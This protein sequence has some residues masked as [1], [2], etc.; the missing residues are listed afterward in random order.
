MTTV[1]GLGLGAGVAFN[2]VLLAAMGDV[3]VD[4]SGLAS[5]LVDTAFMM[6]DAQLLRPRD[7]SAAAAEGIPERGD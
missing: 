1:L 3:A 5:G 4:E 6:G 7:S 2:P